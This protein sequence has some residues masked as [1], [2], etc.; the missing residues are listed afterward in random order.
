MEETNP[1]VFPDAV[2]TEQAEYLA[3]H[4]DL[5]KREAEAYL[6]RQHIKDDEQENVLDRTLAKQMDV[7]K[8]TFSKHLNNAKQKLEG[9][10][11]ILDTLTTL[12]LTTDFSGGGAVSRQVIG[13]TATPN[14]FLLIS[15]TEF[16]DRDA[17]SFPDKYRAHF[18]YRE[19]EPDIDFDELPEDIIHYDKYSLFTVSSSGEQHFV[20]SV[21][22]YVSALGALDSYD[23]LRAVD[24]LEDLGFPG[25]GEATSD[26]IQDA[27][28]EVTPQ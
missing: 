3:D 25:D 28:D 6:R 19:Q 2:Y 4:T 20:D 27:Y 9:D 8:S 11:A 26:A 21:A 7:S 1:P 13:A 10:E 15:E 16:Y 12:F 23:L 5:T 22:A 24:L 14:A 18:V 17:Y